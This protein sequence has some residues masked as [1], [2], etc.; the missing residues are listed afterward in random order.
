MPLP[1]AEAHACQL[2]WPARSL[3]EQ[4]ERQAILDKRMFATYTRINQRI[5]FSSRAVARYGA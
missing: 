4:A 3:C 1:R 5:P 2:C